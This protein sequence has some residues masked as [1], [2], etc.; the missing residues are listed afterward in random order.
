MKVSVVIPTLNAEHWITQQLNML[1][2]Q[3]VEA[4]IL[5]IDSGSTDATC[6]EKAFTGV[7]ESFWSLMDLDLSMTTFFSC[8]DMGFSSV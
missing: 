5:V 1:L 2:S 7:S 6:S 4:E 8:S 3:T